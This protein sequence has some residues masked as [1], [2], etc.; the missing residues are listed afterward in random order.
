MQGML[1]QI[2][3]AKH[4]SDRFKSAMRERT[5]RKRRVDMVEASR[6]PITTLAR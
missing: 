1:K 4:A 6:E 3:Q 5:V 2:L